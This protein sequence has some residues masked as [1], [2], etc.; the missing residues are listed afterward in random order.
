MISPIEPPKIDLT[1]DSSAK[2]DE[3][4]RRMRRPQRHRLLHGYPLAAAMPRV[5]DV[6]NAKY[7]MMTYDPHR[8][9]LIGVL[10]H[11]FCNPAISGCGFCTFPHESFSTRK[12]TVVI[13][14][15]EREIEQRLK[16]DPGLMGRSVA[17]LYF[18]GGT[19]NLSPPEPFRKICRTLAKSFDLS[20][21][22][23]TLEGVPGAFL[24]R[25]PP[26]VD[27]LHEE[28]PARH[29]RLSMGIQTF[30]E[31]RLQQMGRTGF[32]NA[33]TFQEVVR[34][35]HERGFT[36]SGDM[37]INLP[38]QFLEEMRDDVARAIEIGLDHI[39]L[40]HLVLFEGLGTEWSR[41]P[42]LVASLPTNDTAAE[43]WR[44]LRRMLLERGFDQATLTNFERH[45]HR[46]QPTRFQYEELSF[47][48]GRYDI[49]G[50]GPSA[51]SGS[52]T[53]RTAMKVMNPDGALAYNAA[54]D[55]GRTHWDRVFQYSTADLKILHLTRQIAALRINRFDYEQFFGTDPV[56]DFPSEF[57]AFEHEGLIHVTDEMI[58]LTDIGMFYADSIATLLAGKQLRTQRGSRT[59]EGPPEIDLL[60]ENNNAYGHM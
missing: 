4:R 19:A 35:G 55:W 44:E 46:D 15:V 21:A 1:G 37:L 41:D 24:Y 10:P 58:T 54:I 48:P 16:H 56:D 59:N 51:I 14:H 17:A 57:D 34:L 38:G 27:I 39:G 18:G 20:S 12:A 5:E 40:Y 11:P 32:G 33:A 49:I 22:E 6:H 8:G 36:V 52:G 42:D 9:L 43:N 28:L 47:Q 2:L 45:E 30:D 26:L 23:V 31:Q 60:K 3:L 7:Q 53:G 13:E 50:F 29:F 25:K